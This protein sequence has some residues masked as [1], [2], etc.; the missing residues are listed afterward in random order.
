MRY[1]AR[2]ADDAPRLT[3]G[4]DLAERHRNIV[5]VIDRWPGMRVVRRAALN[6]G[7][8]DRRAR[9]RG[10]MEVMDRQRA[11]RHQRRHQ[12]GDDRAP[13]GQHMTILA[14]VNA[15]CLAMSTCKRPLLR[16]DSV[17]CPENDPIQ[18]FVPE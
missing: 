14:L 13:Q 12:C 15:G 9:R 3:T 18:V 11:C 8:D 4:H 16:L 17:S 1:H 5:L 2:L 10:R 7:V 6:M